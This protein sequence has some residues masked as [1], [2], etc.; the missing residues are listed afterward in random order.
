[1]TYPLPCVSQSFPGHIALSTL[2]PSWALLTL[3]IVPFSAMFAI[4]TLHCSGC[5]VAPVEKCCLRPCH[6]TP[7]KGHRSN[8]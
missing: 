5:H 7:P 8:L 3:L 1:M 4:F 6:A 2:F